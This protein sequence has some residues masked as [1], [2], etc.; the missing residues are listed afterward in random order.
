MNLEDYIQ[1]FVSEA[2]K[3]YAKGVSIDLQN[4]L[5]ALKAKGLL[6]K[7]LSGKVGERREIIVEA[8]KNADKILASSNKFYDLFLNNDKRVKFFELAYKY[9][10]NDKDLSHLLHSQLIFAFLLNMETFKNFIL[11]ILEGSSSKD[12][13][14]SLFGKNGLLIIQTKDTG[15]AEKIAQRLDIPLRNSLAHFAFKEEG[16]TICYYSYSKKG[17]ATNLC[18]GRI[19]SSELLSKIHEV[20]LMRAILGCL[21]AD[22]Y[23]NSN[24]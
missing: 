2:M 23:G 16:A 10:F 13:L 22:L 12:T 4:L 18:L 21:I 7:R 3:P 19:Q 14:G 5:F 15:E 1:T 20:S 6:R 24:Y 17:E 8:E 11:L 9:N